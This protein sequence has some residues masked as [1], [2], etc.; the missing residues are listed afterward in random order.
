MYSYFLSMTYSMLLQATYEN[1]CILVSGEGQIRQISRPAGDAPTRNWYTE[2]IQRRYAPFI[3]VLGERMGFAALPYLACQTSLLLGMALVV[4]LTALPVLFALKLG[5]LGGSQVAVVRSLIPRFLA[6]NLG[7][8]FLQLGSLAG[9]QLTILDAVGNAVLLVLLAIVYMVFPLMSLLVLAGADIQIAIRRRW[10][11]G[12]RRSGL[13]SRSS[14][15]GRGLG[16]GKA[17]K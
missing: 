2:G 5:F 12:R 9:A 13:L 16:G 10:R 6:L 14:G 3:R 1:H 8:G 7:L 17:Y 15:G 4:D 11:S